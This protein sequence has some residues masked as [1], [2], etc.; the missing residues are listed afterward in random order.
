MLAAAGPALADESPRLDH[1]GALG[2]ILAGGAAFQETVLEYGVAERGRAP[3]VLGELTFPLGAQ[4]NEW[5]LGVSCAFGDRVTVAVSGGIRAYFGEE[6]WK[7]FVTVE[8]TL[9]VTP[10]VSFGPR[11]GF[12][13]QWDFAQVAGAF[14]QVAAE[15]TAGQGIRFGASAMAGFQFRTY[16]FDSP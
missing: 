16:V 9:H 5:T 8:G 4:G 13:V 3:A 14:V 1:R 15:V 7:T 11:L 2:G 12:G 6:A 10:A